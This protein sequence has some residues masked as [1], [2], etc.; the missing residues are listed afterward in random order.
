MMLR[1]RG[2]GGAHEQAVGLASVLIAHDV[3]LDDVG[4]LHLLGGHAW[5]GH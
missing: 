3:V 1:S 5:F 2:V 4:A